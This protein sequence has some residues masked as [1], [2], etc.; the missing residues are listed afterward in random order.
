[1]KAL[2]AITSVCTGTR[3]A[4]GEQNLTRRTVTAIWTSRV[5]TTVWTRPGRLGAFV[6][7]YSRLVITSHV[8][9]TSASPPLRHRRRQDFTAARG[10]HSQDR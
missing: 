8:H 4:V 10:M 2:N 5:M 3:L 9:Y 6:Y 1:V 7:I